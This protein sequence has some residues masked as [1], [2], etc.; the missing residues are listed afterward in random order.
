MERVSPPKPRRDQ[1][2]TSVKLL[3]RHLSAHKFGRQVAE[4]QIRVAF[5]NGFTALGV[6]AAKVVGWVC[7]GRGKL[8]PSPHLCNRAARTTNSATAAA[9][10]AGQGVWDALR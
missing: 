3:G 7:P 1:D 5:L 9:S 4:F 8:C 6:P 2:A 10:H